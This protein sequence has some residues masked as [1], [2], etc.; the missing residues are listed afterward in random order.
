MCIRDRS[1]AEPHSQIAGGVGEVDAPDSGA[2][3]FDGRTV[4]LVARST[5]EAPW[6]RYLRGLD[7]CRLPL[8][9]R[10]IALIGDQI[11][12]TELDRLVDQLHKDLGQLGRAERRAAPNRGGRSG[13]WAKR[14]RR[15][16]RVNART[17]ELYRRNPSRLAELVL[18]ENLGDLLEEGNRVD[19]PVEAVPY[20]QE[21]WS[22]A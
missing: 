22:T 11:N 13:R 20:F 6:V 3:L 15:R 17:Q 18:N 10:I 4:N 7:V 2:A 12:T 14:T 8:A 1:D 9:Q 16:V 19:P 21:L 5:E